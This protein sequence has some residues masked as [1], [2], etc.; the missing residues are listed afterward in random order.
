MVHPMGLDKPSSNTG[1]NVSGRGSMGF[2]VVDVED[3][4]CTL[5][6]WVAVGG[7]TV[8]GVVDD[9]MMKVSDA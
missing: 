5:V 9:M 6:G 7:G 2:I 1:I 3:E 4:D 8:A